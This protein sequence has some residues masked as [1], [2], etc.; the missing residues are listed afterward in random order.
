MKLFAWQSS[1]CPS[2]VPQATR[3]PLFTTLL[4]LSL[5]QRL[6][7][8]NSQFKAYFLALLAGKEYA[9]VLELLSEVDNS[10]ARTDGVAPRRRSFPYERPSSAPRTTSCV[11][12]FYCGIPGHRVTQ[13]YRKQRELDSA[14]PSYSQG[15][16][17]ASDYRSKQS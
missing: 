17:S 7:V 8:P 3:K 5:R 4:L 1:W 10:F 11:V 9:S 16:K 13:C 15:L 2:P 14:K 6:T 12:C